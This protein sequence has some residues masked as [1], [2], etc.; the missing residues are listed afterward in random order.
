MTQDTAF[1]TRIARRYAARPIADIP[2]YEETLLRTAHYLR[3]TDR[4]LELGCGTGTTA[5]KL[6]DKVARY[7]GTDFSEGMIEVA[8][9]K[10]WEDSPRNLDFQVAAP[11]DD[12]LAGRRFDVVLGFNL[13]HLI[14]DP[15][16]ALAHV[17]RGLEPGGVFISKTPCLGG[18]GAKTLMYRTV[19][20]AMRLLGKAPAVT[21]LS[22]EQWV[23]MV[24]A[25]G[26]EIVERGT[27]PSGSTSRFLVA[28]KATLS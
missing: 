7:T 12:V 25:A 9:E 17:A 11:G 28:R 5:L 18:Q 24:R 8:R 23:G 2:A 19:V 3:D 4:V 20:G 10:A 13:F 21:F 27:Y 16:A 15:Q 26:F 1:W 22:T 14:A 6:R